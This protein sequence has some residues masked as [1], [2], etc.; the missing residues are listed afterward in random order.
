MDQNFEEM[1]V[2]KFQ[3]LLRD[4]CC[5]LPSLKKASKNQAILGIILSILTLLLGAVGNFLL[6]GL[7]IISPPIGYGSGAVYLVEGAL[8]L[9]YNLFLLRSVRD[10]Q[11]LRVFRI[12]KVGCLI[13]LYLQLIL[14]V[15]ALLGIVILFAQPSPQ[16]SVGGLV[17]A[18][19]ID[20]IALFLSALPI[21]AIH[22]VK[23]K[24]V[25]VYI[26]IMSIL[27]TIFVIIGII[28]AFLYLHL[29]LVS[30]IVLVFKLDYYLKIFVLHLNMMTVGSVNKNHHQ[31]INT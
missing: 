30:F 5:S 15:L 21:Y 16:V 1:Q 10:N 24:I 26:Y 25:S 19:L 13:F 29:V 12:I 18:L 9:I 6:A 20:F 2:E 8:F 17:A 7:H 3:C 11:G 23:P 31:L 28:G 22:R 14:E 4:V 27:F